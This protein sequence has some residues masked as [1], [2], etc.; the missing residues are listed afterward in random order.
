MYGEQLPSWSTASTALP[1]WGSQIT[2]RNAPRSRVKRPSRQRRQPARKIRSGGRPGSTSSS[3]AVDSSPSR[4]PKIHAEGS[5]VVAPRSRTAAGPS[6]RRARSRSPS[7]NAPRAPTRTA[8][9][10]SLRATRISEL[11]ETLVLIVQGREESEAVAFDPRVCLELGAGG[12]ADDECDVD[13]AARQQRGEHERSHEAPGVAG[14]VLERAPDRPAEADGS[15]LR[16]ESV[17]IRRSGS[18]PPAQAGEDDRQL[19]PPQQQADPSVLEDDLGRQGDLLTK[20]KR[21]DPFVPCRRDRRRRG[22]PSSDA[23]C[24]ATAADTSAAARLPGTSTRK[25]GTALAIRAD[26]SRC[27]SWWCASER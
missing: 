10:A 3:R 5:D 2:T 14:D 9:A 17:R 22:H 11:D 18:S 26:A 8:R 21:P 1:G 6:A 23:A 13:A 12:D 4:R 16:G 25:S 15:G 19:R 20:R 7:A 24:S 27:A